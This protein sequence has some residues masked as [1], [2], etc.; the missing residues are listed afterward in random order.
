MVI[1]TPN[2][3][4]QNNTVEKTQLQLILDRLDKQD[5]RF[6]NLKKRLSKLW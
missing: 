3:K 4:E 1:D 6:L 2:T 5:Q